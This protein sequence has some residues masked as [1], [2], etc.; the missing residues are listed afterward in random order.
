M[1]NIYIHISLS[2]WPHRFTE[3]Q[4]H[5]APTHVR[6]LP[7]KLKSKTKSDFVCIRMECCTCQ[8][9]L[10]PSI[11]CHK[12][13]GPPR[14][15]V[16]VL[17]RL[18]RCPLTL[19][20]TSTIVGQTLCIY[21]YMI[22]AEESITPVTT[23]YARKSSQSFAHKPMRQTHTHSGVQ[24]QLDYQYEHAHAGFWTSYDPH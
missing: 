4:H 17:K 13:G 12:G 2:W 15:C 20:Q 16:F 6:S 10:R 21:I 24:N 23:C 1:Y 22:Q 11:P 8:S 3:H 5:L 7:G 14:L 19:C 18:P 9:G